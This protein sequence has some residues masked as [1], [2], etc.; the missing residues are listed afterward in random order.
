MLSR[1]YQ[2]ASAFD[3]RGFAADPENKLVWRQ[4]KRRLDAECVC[5]AIF[6][7]AGTLDLSEPAGSAIAMAG[8]GPIG[9]RRFVGVSEDVLVNAN[10]NVRSVYLA[11]ARDML[12][13]AL[14]VFDF[15]EPSLVTGAR[16]TTNVPSQALFLL[17]SPFA[18]TQAQK[19]AERVLAAHP[20]GPNA[21]VTANLDARVTAAYW[22]A[23]GRAPT[24]GERQAASAFFSRVPSNWSKGDKSAPGLPDAS[25]AK[26]AWTSF[27]RALFAS[28][29][30]RYLN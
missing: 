16:E 9:Q 10:S 4:D 21:G 23:F 24:A 17:N 14:A 12:P 29:E 1:S 6:S 27:C 25:D 5:D 26:A 30:F 22:T 13:D 11:V 15:A 18:T 28:A 19:F 3:E 8:D 20:G 2:L 7:A